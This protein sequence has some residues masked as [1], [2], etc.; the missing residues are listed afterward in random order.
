ME[1]K[2]YKKTLTL[3]SVKIKNMTSI[4]LKKQLHKAIDTIENTGFLKAVYAM[5]KE[6]SEEEEGSLL[7][8]DQK[9]EL[10]RRIELHKKGKSK[11]YTRGEVQKKVLSK[12]KK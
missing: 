10:D 12:L 11:N 6:Y 2:V 8:E 7:A 4:T 5:L 3:Y 9:K 1:I